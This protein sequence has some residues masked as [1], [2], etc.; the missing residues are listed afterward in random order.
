MNGDEQED[1]GIDFNQGLGFG[2]SSQVVIISSN[3]Q[4]CS[5]DGYP[6]GPPDHLIPSNYE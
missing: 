5:L 6:V 2:G 1:L 4:G 3:R